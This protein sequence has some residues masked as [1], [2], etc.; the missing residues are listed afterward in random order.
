M[1]GTYVVTGCAG[2]LGSNLV[3]R[4]LEAGHHV[5]GIDNLSMGK[6]ENIAEFRDEPRFRFTQADVTDP[7]ALA[8][9][10]S[11]VDAIVHL[12]AFKIPRYGKA[13]DTLKINYRG[14][15]NALDFARRLGCKLVLASTSDIYGRNPKLPFSEKDSDSVIGNSKSPRWAYAVSKLFDEHLALAYQDAYG[16]PVTILRFF[17]SYGPK[18]PLSWWGGPPPVFIDCVLNDKPI[19]IHG[20]GSQTR[21]FTYASDTV[22]GI[23]QALIRPEANGEIINIGSTQETTILDLAR[24]IKRLSGTPGDIRIDFVPYASFTGQKYEDVMRRVPDVSLC[25][26]LLGV[27]ARVD[28]DEGL[29]RTIEWQRRVTA[30]AAS[31]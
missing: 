2:F 3:G 9:L 21:S 22:E 23:Y 19:P 25:E 5:L 6:L 1:T 16:F 10:D 12:A 28:I 17:G 29:R 30:K 26:Q 11:K 24:R 31:E 14:T 13:I 15:E 4:L 27:R 18:Q 7:Q 8:G 20:D